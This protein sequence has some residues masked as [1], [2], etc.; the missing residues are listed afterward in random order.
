MRATALALLALL[1]LLLAGCGPKP[2][3][4][5]P[6]PDWLL[7]DWVID[8]DATLKALPDG[9]P[10]ADRLPRFQEFSV[11]ITPQQ[12]VTRFGAKEKAFPYMVQGVLP[13]ACQ[14][15]IIDTLRTFYF[16]RVDGGI[17]VKWRQ[18]GPA[19]DIYLKK[20]S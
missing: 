8:N 1:P 4:A 2:P 9:S 17:T 11:S 3:A 16:Q 18:G 12:L 7:G 15:G 5:I 14:I 13:D 10:M 19:L 20:K 6:A